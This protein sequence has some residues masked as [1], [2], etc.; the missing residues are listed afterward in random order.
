[1]LEPN[2]LITGS[3][4]FNTAFEDKFDNVSS[5][6]CAVI[7]VDTNNVSANFSIVALHIF[8]GEIFKMLQIQL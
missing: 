8:L 6:D 5:I 3:E 2:A 7:D 1:M 4:Y